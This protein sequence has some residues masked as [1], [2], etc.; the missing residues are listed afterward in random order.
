MIDEKKFEELEKSQDKDPR[1]APFGCFLG[2]SGGWDG[3]LMFWYETIESL[4]HSLLELHPAV[5]EI[6]AD[7][8]VAYQNG[9][10]SI[11]NEATDDQITEEMLLAMNDNSKT[12]LEIS[13]HGKFDE[14]V[15]G[16]SEFSKE[17]RENYRE[18]DDDS[19]IENHEIEDFIEFLKTFG[20]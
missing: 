17:V 9:L 5:Y 11:F 10:K 2:S 3:R 19:I 16:E 8:L 20:I 4:K 1:K 13:W 12:W 18:P 7:E 14:L 15:H 6:E